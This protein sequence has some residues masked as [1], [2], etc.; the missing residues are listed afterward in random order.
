MG[1]GLDGAG[2]VQGVGGGDPEGEGVE[3]LVEIVEVLVARDSL[4]RLGVLLAVLVHPCDGASH[5]LELGVPGLEGGVGDSE[6]ILVDGPVLGVDVHRAVGHGGAG[7]GEPA[8][9]AFGYLGGEAA[10]LARCILEFVGLVHDEYV[11]SDALDKGG[12]GFPVG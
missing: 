5:R 8:G 1:V 3:E 10:Y 6:D 2:Q 9:A 11:P 12:Q 7:E 4:G